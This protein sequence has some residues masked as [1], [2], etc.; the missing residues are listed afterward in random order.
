MIRLYKLYTEPQTFEPIIFELGINLII[1][2]KT[3]ENPKTN[4]VGKTMCIEFIN[5]CLLKDKKESRV[6]KIP[7][8]DYP[9]D[10]KIILDLEI[11]S[12]YLSIIRTRRHPDIITIIKEGREI[13]FDNIEQ[14]TNYLSSL[15]FNNYSNQ[16]ILPSFRQLLAPLMRDERSE[17]K[18]VVNCFNTKSRIPSDFAPHLYLLG[19][20][21]SIYKELKKTISEIEKSNTYLTKLKHE[22]TENGTVKISDVKAKLNDLADEVKRINSAIESLKSNDAFESIHKDLILIETKLD[23]LRN[24]QKAI[25]YEINKIQSFPEHEV[26]SPNDISILY[27]QFKQGLGDLIEKSLIEVASFK[28]KIDNFRK[29]L[30]NSKLESLTAELNLNAQKIGELDNQ[31]SEKLR[32]ID[33]GKV[34]KDLRT[35]LSVYNSKSE[36]LNKIRFQWTSYENAKKEKENVLDKKR[37]DLHFELKDKL[38]KMASQIKTFEETILDIHEKIMYNRKASFQINLSKNK[39]IFEFVLWID[40]AGGHSTERTKVFIYDMA[41]LFNEQ[42]KQQHPRF[43]I[44]DNIFDVD[45][46]TLVQCLNYLSAQEELY[47]NDFQYILTLNRD[48]IEN[49][50]RKRLIKIDVDSHKRAEFTKENRFLKMKYKEK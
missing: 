33:N 15:F 45:Q 48:K 19:F 36:E 20:D 50:E 37:S 23:S 42:T 12:N 46:D 6:M 44:H 21:I 31:Y 38:D 39:D 49:E 10:I 1:G 9:L 32:L 13:I 30:V 7:E 22:I 4:S 17:F 27:N 35:G 25:K 40:D 16:S 18:D 14:A 3:T 29:S 34:L 26:I 41:L 11:S 47:P 43:L 28:A 24:Q 8:T 5:F 2:E